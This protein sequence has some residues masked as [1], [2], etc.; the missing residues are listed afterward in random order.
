VLSV[1]VNDV[2]RDLVTVVERTTSDRPGSR[3]EV[4]DTLSSDDSGVFDAQQI[5]TVPR[6]KL[7]QRLGALTSEQLA[8]V[9]T[10]VKRW[11]GLQ[12]LA[13]QPRMPRGGRVIDLGPGTGEI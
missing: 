2:E 6:R 1:P 3:F 11:L 5:I 13:P 10:A 8:N 7:Q 4:R 12:P 9:E